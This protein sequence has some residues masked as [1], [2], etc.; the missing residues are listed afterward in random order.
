MHRPGFAPLLSC[1]LALA[2]VSLAGCSS[3]TGLAGHREP[4]VDGTRELGEPAVVLVQLAGGVGSCTGTLISPR[5]VLTAKHCVQL[6]GSERPAAASLFT[7][8]VG[9]SRSDIET[10]RVQSVLAPPGRMV[11]GDGADIGLVIL[12]E[13]VPGVEPIA[14][15]R[16]APNELIGQE[17][18]AIGFG[19]TREREVGTKYRTTTTI[20]NVTTSVLEAR[21]TICQGDSGGPIILE[22]D[23]TRP[24]QVV[25]VASY[26]LAANQGDCPAMLDAWNRVD[27]FIDL[28]DLAVLRAGGCVERGEETCNSLDDDCDGIFDEGCAALGEPCESD[29]ECAF[30]PLPEALREGMP[31]TAVCADVGGARRCAFPCDPL[32]PG[33]SCASISPA[34]GTE[35][36]ATPGFYCAAT[37]GCDGLCVA[38]EAGAAGEGEA[39]ASDTDCASL[40]CAGGVCATAC[41][42]GALACPSDEVCGADAGACGVCVDPAARPSGR[43][44]G[45]VCDSPE[46]CAGLG[47]GPLDGTTQCTSACVGDAEC[48]AGMRCEGGFCARG[49]RAGR[50]GTC[51][52]DADCTDARCIARDG[53]RYCAPRC[54]DAASCAGGTC[55]SVDGEMRCLPD[56]PVLG[57][58]CDGSI[59][60]AQGECVDA[61]CTA[62]CGGELTCP[63]GHDCVREG[64]GTVC[65]PRATE[66]GGCAVS[67]GSS[68]SGALPMLVLAA[69]VLA[70]AQRR[71]PRW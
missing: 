12:R 61:V 13:E 44:A 1:A 22:S 48:G 56:A 42:G 17:V 47:C 43:S 27:T 63:I 24:R 55:A 10:F 59:A 40:R 16:E 65:R 33:A 26:G 41:R 68:R 28:I 36:V 51:R 67:P 14:V 57:E 45:E 49:E 66:G 8:G 9:S 23:G 70:I 21:N 46:Q 2:L 32:S 20:E 71:R 50:F 7:V 4:I 18:T 69:L 29:G 3:D 53:A 25:G 58:P 30:G 64:V 35:P 11:I 39:C 15:R 6:Q 54:T 19:T 38:G 60:C 62:L 52:S 34:F 5:V 31:P 37:A